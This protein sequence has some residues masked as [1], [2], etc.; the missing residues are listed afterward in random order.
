MKVAFFDTKGYDRDYFSQQSEKWGIQMEF[1]PFKLRKETVQLIQGFEAVCVFVNDCLD[2]G[3]L[4]ELK[5]RGVRK[6]VL[7]CAGYNNVD[8]EAAKHFGLKVYRVPA[9]SPW[10]VAEHTLVL[11]LNLSRKIHK[12]YNRVRE[13]NFSLEGLVGFDVHRKKVGVV[14]TGKIGK[15]F[16]K[17]LKGLECEV[18][19]TDLVEDVDL[20][21]LGV[22][23]GRLDEWIG[24]VDILSL[25]VPLTQET[26]HLMSRERLWRMRKGAILLNTSRGALVD[27]KG[28]IDVLKKGHLGGAGLDVYEEEQNYFFSD[29]SNQIVP[30]DILMRLL[31]F[32]NVILTAHQGFLTHEAL[33]QITQVTLENLV[34][35]DDDPEWCVSGRL[36]T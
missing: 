16:C 18:I 36:L 23:Y 25:H 34:A 6:I 17:I 32:P 30:D 5:T 2:S 31:T 22:K 8:L 33:L 4:G 7:R 26:Y 10:A 20:K 11:L 3:V 19:A 14:G 27:T 1:F 13:G 9:Y 29:W 35:S 21:A 15:A 28:L 12:A 24:E